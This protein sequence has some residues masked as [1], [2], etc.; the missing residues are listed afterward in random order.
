MI[1]LR[2]PG[3]R[4]LARDRQ[5]PRAEHELARAHG[6]RIGGHLGDVRA[7]DLL[8][9]AGAVLE[10]D[11]IDRHHDLVRGEGLGRRHR[12]RGGR[13]ADMRIPHV[14]EIGEILGAGDM[15]VRLDA[16]AEARPRRAERALDFLQG[17][18]GLA[19]DRQLG[20]PQIMRPARRVGS[21]DVLDVG[22]RSR[23][24]HEIVRHHRRR[25]ARIGEE[26]GVLRIDACTSHCGSGTTA[27]SE[28]V[29][30]LLAPKQPSMI[31]DVLGGMY[32]PN[33]AN[34]AR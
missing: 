1:A 6:R 19:P 33:A 15:D 14:E 7:H 21:A 12:E 18:F 4:S 3:D 25:V 8:A 2:E 29:M 34:R 5:Q 10:Q 16:I 28:V 31:I 9:A 32:L 27:R 17:G 26:G 24:E 30:V 20:A 11:V 22:S 13:A 23:R